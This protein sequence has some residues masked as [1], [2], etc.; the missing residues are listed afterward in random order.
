LAKP[1][2]WYRYWGGEGD[3]IGILVLV[4]IPVP[5]SFGTGIGTGTDFGK[6]TDGRYH[7][8]ITDNW[9]FY[10]NIHVYFNQYKGGERAFILVSSKNM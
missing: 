9:Y 7:G 10:Q 6:T 8:K 3:V 4:P 5:E 1:V 2:F